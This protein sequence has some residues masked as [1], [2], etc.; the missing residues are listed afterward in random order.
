MTRGQVIDKFIKCQNTSSK[1]KLE[2]CIFT[3][4]QKLWFTDTLS[5]FFNHLP[6]DYSLEDFMKNW[7][8]IFFI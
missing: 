1:N 3:S 6:V 7:F 2:N 8:K 5:C 4:I